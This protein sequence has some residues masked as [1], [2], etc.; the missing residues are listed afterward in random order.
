MIVEEMSFLYVYKR[1]N[2]SAY[3]GDVWFD[4]EMGCPPQNE[5]CLSKKGSGC[6]DCPCMNLR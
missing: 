5:I 1:V 4:K 2:L 6:D 3:K